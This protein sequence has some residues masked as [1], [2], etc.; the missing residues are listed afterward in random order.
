MRLSNLSTTFKGC[1]PLNQI[2]KMSDQF[3]C[4]TMKQIF[5]R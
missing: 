5:V 4:K 2:P 1:Y 3:A